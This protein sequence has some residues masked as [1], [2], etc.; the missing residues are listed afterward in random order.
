MWYEIKLQIYS[1]ACGYPVF[2]T[3]F[4]EKNVHS[5]LNGLG[6]LVKTHL[7]TYMQRIISWLFILFHW[8]VCL[9]LCQYHTVEIAAVPVVSFVWYCDL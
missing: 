6:T 5:P 2:P 7:A 8:F 1:F 9:S 4:L 3:P